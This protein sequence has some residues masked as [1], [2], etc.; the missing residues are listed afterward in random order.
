MLAFHTD[1]TIRDGA[2]MVTDTIFS[3]NRRC[4]V[5]N[6]NFWYRVMLSYCWRTFSYPL[7]H[8]IIKNSN[9]ATVQQCKS[10]TDCRVGLCRFSKKRCRCRRSCFGFRGRS[11]PSSGR[12]LRKNRLDRSEKRPKSSSCG[13]S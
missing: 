8:R 11:G 4:R 10:I 5:R 1:A 9:I 3:H 13:G 2:K 12:R 7:I 6:I